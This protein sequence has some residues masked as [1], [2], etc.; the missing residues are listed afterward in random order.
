MKERLLIWGIV[1]ALFV[2]IGEA[3]RSSVS[4]GSFTTCE[5][6]AGKTQCVFCNSKQLCVSGSVIGPHNSTEGCSDWR[7]LQC[8]YSRI[9]VDVGVVSAIVIVLIAFCCCTLCCCMW[10]SRRR[11][12]SPRHSAEYYEAR[13]RAE[14]ERLMEARKSKTPQTDKQRDEMHKKWGIGGRST[15]DERDDP[16]L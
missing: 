11:R 13:K 1:V 4:C 5:E 9:W 8:S 16:F 6:C 2:A 3:Q 12:S 10:C 15:T 14:E 7:W